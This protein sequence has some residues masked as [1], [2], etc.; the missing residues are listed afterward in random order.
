MRLHILEKRTAEPLYVKLSKAE[1]Y[2]STKLAASA[3]ELTPSVFCDMSPRK[4]TAYL[5][6]G[7]QHLH[8]SFF[9]LKFLSV[10]NPVDDQGVNP[11]QGC[12]KRE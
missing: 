7:G 6:R 10:I 8:A 11:I 1:V 5:T 3:A 9:K 4:K 12:E 2:F